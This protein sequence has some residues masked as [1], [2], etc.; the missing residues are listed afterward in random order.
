MMWLLMRYM[1]LRFLA[2]MKVSCDW[3]S[4]AVRMMNVVNN[5]VRSMFGRPRSLRAM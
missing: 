4:M 1:L 3:S 5:Y 2:N